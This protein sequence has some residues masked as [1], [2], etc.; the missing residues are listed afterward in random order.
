MSFKAKNFIVST[1]GNDFTE[2]DMAKNAP[3][4]NALGMNLDPESFEPKADG[5]IEEKV[6]AEEK[7][8]A[9]EPVVV[10][11]IV[12]KPVQEE[13]PNEE[14]AAGIDDVLKRVFRL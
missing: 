13:V 14:P 11:E 10:A 8:V 12:E 9:P 5:K 4:A 7:T 3:K 2:I 6:A 1:R